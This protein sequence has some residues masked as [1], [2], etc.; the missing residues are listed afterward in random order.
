MV[1]HKRLDALTELIEHSGAKLIAVGDGKQ[2]PSIGPGG[3]FDRLTGHAPK[4]ELETIHRTTDP[5]EQKAWQALRAGEPERAMAHYQARGRLHLVDTRDQAAE[6]AVQAWAQLTREVGVGNRVDRGLL[7]QGDRQA[8][9]PRTTPTRP[10]RRTRPKRTSPLKRPLRATARRSCRIHRPTPP[11]RPTTSGE[12]HAR[13]SHEHR[14]GRDAHARPRRVRPPATA[15]TPRRRVAATRLRPTR[16]PPTRCDCR[17]R[18]RAHRRLANKQGDRLR[19]SHPSPQ[20][21]RL[22]PRPRPTRHRRSRP[23][24]D[25]APRRTDEPEPS[26]HSICHPPTDSRT[27]MET[28]PRSAK[29]QPRDAVCGPTHANSSARRTR[30]RR[31]TRTLTGR[32]S[33][34]HSREQQ[35][36]C[37][38]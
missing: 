21:H 4:V 10:T 23:R 25:H 38:A 36:F 15:R 30:S 19:T 2:L 16:L 34:W 8:Q 11:A 28:Q 14:P 1:D 33:H 26:A 5:Y 35:P 27:V 3:M 9:R 13:P 18:D 29:P 20:R 37:K 32:D 24:P 7:E 6:S 17:S 31:G 12:R 22:V